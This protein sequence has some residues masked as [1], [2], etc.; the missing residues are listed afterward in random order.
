MVKFS[1][2]SQKCCYLQ[3]VFK[4]WWFQTKQLTMLLGFIKLY[5]QNQL[6]KIL[7]FTIYQNYILALSFN[8]ALNN[9]I[10]RAF[11]TNFF[12]LSSNFMSSWGSVQRV[13]AVLHANVFVSQHCWLREFAR[14]LHTGLQVPR[15]NG[16]TRIQ[17]Y[18]T[19]RLP[20]IDYRQ[21]VF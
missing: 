5:K 7:I 10:L 6:E 15:R 2:A 19:W 14:R 8:R 3:N 12:L 11:L 4:Y 16:T 21:T 18:S 13:F 9:K 20:S 1:G 17:M